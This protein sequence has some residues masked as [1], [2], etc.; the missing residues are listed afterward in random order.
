[1]GDLSKD[2][3][4]SEF[5]CPC[6]CGKNNISLSLVNQLQKLRDTLEI[7]LKINSGC[8]CEK[9][10]E[11]VG[12]TSGSSHLKGLAADISC[13]NSQDRFNLVWK[14]VDLFCRIGIGKTFVHVDVDESLPQCVMWGYWP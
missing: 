2:F 8:R 4:R 1:M 3:D 11:E 7:P 14:S 10:N 12:G 5:S 6:G 9:H 13:I